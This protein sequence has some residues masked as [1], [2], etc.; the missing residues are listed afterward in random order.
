MFGLRFVSLAL[1]TLL[2]GNAVAAPAPAP[3]YNP[4]YG[5]IVHVAPIDTTGALPGPGAFTPHP[6]I[7]LGHDPHGN[8]ILAPVTHNAHSNDLKPHMPTPAEHGLEGVTRL[9]HIVA[10]HPGAVKQ[11]YGALR[12]KVMSAGATDRIQQGK[13]LVQ[14]HYGAAQAHGLAAQA[15]RGSEA[16]HNHQSAQH[17]QTGNA[18]LGAHHASQAALYRGHAEAHEAS[19]GHHNAA[20][21]AVNG[22]NHAELQHAQN[23]AHF[24]HGVHSELSAAA[25]HHQNAAGFH[26]VGNHV[27]AQHESNAATTAH[28]NAISHSHTAV[29]HA[30]K[31]TAHVQH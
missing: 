28:N 23:S 27:T 12:G 3:F 30:N 16:Y 21:K 10:L 22:P 8:V 15:H 9:D 19:A 7:A 26:A 13:G 4:Q 18:Q 24:A 14:A 31:A 17:F 20:A 1:A 5:E 11:S 25:Q 29:Y 2:F 6:H